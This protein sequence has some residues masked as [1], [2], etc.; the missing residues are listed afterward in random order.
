MRAGNN[1]RRVVRWLLVALVAGLAQQVAAAGP[2]PKL[3]RA[4]ENAA[5]G[6]TEANRPF[7]L[8][9]Y[10]RLRAATPEQHRGMV[11][12]L[13]EKRLLGILETFEA[14]PAG[15]NPLGT[16]EEVY[17]VMGDLTRPDYG[18]AVDGLDTTVR[19]LFSGAQNPEKGALLDLKIADEVNL[20]SKQGAFQKTISGGGVSRDYDVF[21]PDPL[22]PLGGVCHENKNWLSPLDGPN[23]GRL[24]GLLEEFQRDIRVQNGSD[25]AFFRLNLRQV[26]APQ[27]DMI[28]AQLLQ[29]FDSPIVVGALGP[30]RAAD[31]RGIF[32]DRWPDLVKFY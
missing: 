21:E 6:I 12:A 29:E 19:T 30:A 28:L 4:M 32:L 2:C 20:A 26:V 3:A 13:L 11:K 15:A 7:A 9:W 25:F 18:Q 14:L 16:A 10:A 5:D 31:L 27:A 17:R 22:S 24:L 1:T 8:Q 23:D